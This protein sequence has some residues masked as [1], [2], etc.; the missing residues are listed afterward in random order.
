MD[1]TRADKATFTLSAQAGIAERFSRSPSFP[2]GHHTQCPLSNDG[3]RRSQHRAEERGGSAD[4]RSGSSRLSPTL[5]GPGSLHSPA[6]AFLFGWPRGAQ[7][8]T[9]SPHPHLPPQTGK[10]TE[11][12]T[13]PSLSQGVTRSRTRSIFVFKVN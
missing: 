4:R 3:D 6:R 8:G 11:N 13:T 2:L 5:R 10:D 12:N 9:A 7:A 1:W